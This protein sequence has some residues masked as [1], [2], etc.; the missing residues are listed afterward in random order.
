L[1]IACSSPLSS[2][3]VDEHNSTSSERLAQI[4]QN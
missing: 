4:F 3:A 1:Y 2:L